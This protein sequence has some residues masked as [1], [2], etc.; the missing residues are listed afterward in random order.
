MKVA[1]YTQAAGI[2]G[3]ASSRKN[4]IV[5]YKVLTVCTALCFMLS[6]GFIDIVL[7]LLP[8]HH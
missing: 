1:L 6:D 7:W 8:S 5:I 4:W 2:C 3:Q